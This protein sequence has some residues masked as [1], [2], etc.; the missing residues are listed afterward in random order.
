MII[1][2]MIPQSLK[3]LLVVFEQAEQISQSLTKK[4]VRKT[5]IKAFF[6]VSDVGW[7]A[8]N[9]IE[10]RRIHGQTCRR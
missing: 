10:S 8:K 1:R 4:I 7:D 6:A 9:G 3:L 2:S 5:G